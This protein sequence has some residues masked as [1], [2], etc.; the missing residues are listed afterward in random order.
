MPKRVLLVL[1]MMAAVDPE[2]SIRVTPQTMFGGQ[3]LRLTCRVPRDENNRW[4]EMGVDGYTSSTHQLDGAASR[5]TW[6]QMYHHIPCGTERVF[7][8]LTK[9]G[10]RTRQ[11]SASVTVVCGE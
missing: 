4:L 10:G 9:A 5:V 6:E 11:V 2:V 1:L 3:S 8:V 7:C